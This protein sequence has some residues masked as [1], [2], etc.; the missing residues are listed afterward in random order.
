MVL[1]Y[2]CISFVLIMVAQIITEFEKST[3]GGAPFIRSTAFIITWLSAGI[4]L[5]T[6]VKCVGNPQIIKGMRARKRGLP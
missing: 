3:I 6:L 2:I 1:L 5:G 4:M